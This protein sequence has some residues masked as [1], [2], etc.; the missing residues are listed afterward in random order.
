MSSVDALGIPASLQPANTAASIAAAAT[1]RAPACPFALC[2]PSLEHGRLGLREVDAASGSAAPSA[3]NSGRTFMVFLRW[4]GLVLPFSSANA[5]APAGGSFS[6]VRP[7][8][9]AAPP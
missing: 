6:I 7:G 9:G 5:E 1:D 2:Q 3:V 4:S 8:T